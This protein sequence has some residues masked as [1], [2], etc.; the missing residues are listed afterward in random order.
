MNVSVPT[1]ITFSP[2]ALQRY[3]ERIA[4]TQLTDSLPLQLAK[5]AGFSRVMPSAPDWLTRTAK[6]ESQLY[7]TVG[8]DVVFPLVYDD[9]SGAWVAK[10][11]LTKGGLSP[12]ARERRNSAK[13]R[14][15]ARRHR[16]S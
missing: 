3:G 5:L 15:R 2:H 6:D 7:L 12:L 14:Q 4:I 16:S 13:A 10:T 8:G 9:R 11:C 1:P